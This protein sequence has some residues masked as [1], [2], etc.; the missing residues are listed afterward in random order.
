V[1]KISLRDVPARV[2]M[3]LLEYADA[4]GARRDGLELEL[5]RTQDQLAAELATTRESIERALGRLRK[6]GII[7]QA[8]SRVRINSAARLEAVAHPA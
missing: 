8:G 7:D 1:E 5:P 2:A 3:T 6:D 4:A